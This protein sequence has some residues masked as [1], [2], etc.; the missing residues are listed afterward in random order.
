MQN[1][2]TDEVSGTIIVDGREFKL[3]R[4]FFGSSREAAEA[5]YHPKSYWAKQGRE[6]VEVERPALVVA[7]SWRT[8]HPAE[9]EL[10]LANSLL[11]EYLVSVPKFMPDIQSRGCWWVYTG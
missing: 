1:K 6:V 10:V 8:Y 4:V 2:T 9:D 11:N 7:K 5:G 3:F